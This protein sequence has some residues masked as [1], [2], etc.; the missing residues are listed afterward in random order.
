MIK[1]TLYFG[2][3][4]YPKTTNEQII[5]EIQDIIK[6]NKIGQQIKISAGNK[7]IWDL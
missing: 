6:K 7:K 3:P 2:N 4:A 1:P 5:I